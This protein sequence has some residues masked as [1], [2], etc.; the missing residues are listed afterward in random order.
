MNLESAEVEP[1]SLRN[2]RIQLLSP[3]QE[4]GAMP[5]PTNAPWS[6]DTLVVWDGHGHGG[7]TAHD[8]GTV[9]GMAQ[10]AEARVENPVALVGLVRKGIDFQ[11]AD[12]LRNGFHV[13][14]DHGNRCW[15][16]ICYM[17][18]ESILVTCSLP[19]M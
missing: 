13:L 7:A 19:E 18:P 3:P 4:A 14:R 16:Y 8:H 12:P 15:S 10:L 1:G 5:K 6:K 2:F 17:T 9:F 11:S